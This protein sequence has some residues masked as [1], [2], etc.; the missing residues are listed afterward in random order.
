M[1]PM[2]SLITPNT[3]N[4]LFGDHSS[5]IYLAFLSRGGNATVNLPAGNWRYRP[6]DP[7]T[8]SFIS[9][10]ASLNSGLL[11]APN[12]TDRAFL[13]FEAGSAN[14]LPSVSVSF[15]ADGSVIPSYIPSIPVKASATDADGII[16]KV[17]FY[18]NDTLA[19]TDLSA[20]YEYLLTSPANGFLDIRVVAYDDSLGTSA[21]SIRIQIMDFPN[22]LP[23]VSITSPADSSIYVTGSSIPINATASDVDGTIISVELYIN[24]VRIDSITAEPYSYTW[25]NVPEGEHI[26][27]VIAYDDSSTYAKDSIRIIVETIINIPPVIEIT[28][29]HDSSVITTGDSISISAT[30]Y[31]ADGVID[32]VAFLINNTLVHTGYTDP[33]TFWWHNAQTGNYTLVAIAYDDSLATGTDTITFN[34]EERV[35]IPPTVE[36]TQPAN[37]STFI[38]GDSIRITAAVYDADSII[39]S[40]AFLIN[41]TLVHTGYTDPYTFWWHTAVIGSYTL[42]AI[43]YDDSLATGSDTVFIN[44]MPPG[45]IYITG[46]TLINTNTSLPVNGFDPIPDSAVINRAVTGD[47]L[48]IRANV[49]QPVGSIRFDLN[50]VERRIESQ[51]PYAM[52]GDNSGIYNSWTPAVGAYTVKG[53]AYSLTNAQGSLLDTLSV[54][55]T[56]IN[57]TPPS[58]RSS[59]LYRQLY[60]NPANSELTIHI[61]ESE[62][63]KEVH[64][65]TPV[66]RKYTPELRQINRNVVKVDTE[67]LYP[68]IYHIEIVTENGRTCTE[69]FRK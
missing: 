9:T 38:E 54:R 66:G 67:Q 61:D 22:E 19:A 11:Q 45:T 39:D 64:L 7:V 17:E 5:K 15:P 47:N 28:Q 36:I 48:N 27:K 55:F 46:F 41:N 24:D 42:V 33:Y 69:A 43:A 21:D 68:G 62:V 6:Y 52:T 44:V 40:V 57:E 18:I 3:N 4:W 60:P 8:G 25:T 34:V 12:N 2:D 50:G 37:N 10:V 13:I 16:S 31:D 14:M 58:L 56:V 51:A 65:I 20:P 53:Y 29:P 63:I 23:A 49:N 32:S 35:N 30:A 59:A 1:V 26:I